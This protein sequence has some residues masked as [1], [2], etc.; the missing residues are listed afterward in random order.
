MPRKFK[1]IIMLRAEIDRRAAKNKLEEV[2][3]RAG[4]P[5]ISDRESNCKYK[6][7]VWEKPQKPQNNKADDNTFVIPVQTWRKSQKKDKFNGFFS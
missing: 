3:K 2:I 1:T 4:S 6:G 7:P 5:R